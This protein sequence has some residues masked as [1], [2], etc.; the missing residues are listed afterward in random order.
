MRLIAL[1]L[2]SALVLMSSVTPGQI[3]E[4][5]SALISQ[6]Y[7]EVALGDLTMCSTF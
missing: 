5:L 7:N 4:L 2:A 1:V 3:T 6:P